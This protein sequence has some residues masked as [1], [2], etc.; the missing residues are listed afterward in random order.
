VRQGGE[1]CVDER[2]RELGDRGGAVDSGAVRLEDVEGALR[3]IAHADGGEYVERRLVD[4]GDVAYI[5]EVEAQPL[6][7]VA[8]GGVSHGGGLL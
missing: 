8:G 5:D 7:D 2:G 3:V 4:A 6:A 1:G